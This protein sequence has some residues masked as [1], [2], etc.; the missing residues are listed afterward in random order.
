MFRGNGAE[1]RRVPRLKGPG[2]ARGVPL[3]RYVE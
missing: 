3:S 1:K 2:A